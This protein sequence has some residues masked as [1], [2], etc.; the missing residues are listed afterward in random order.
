MG[1]TSARK[2]GRTEWQANREIKLWR[3]R[4]ERALQMHYS[5]GPLI[6]LL[7]PESTPLH[8]SAK[9]HQPL[10]KQNQPRLS[11]WQVRHQ[12]HNMHWRIPCPCFTLFHCGMRSMFGD[13]NVSHFKSQAGSSSS[14]KKANSSNK[15]RDWLQVASYQAVRIALRLFFLGKFREGSVS[16]DYLPGFGQVAL[17][18]ITPSKFLIPQF[19]ANVHLSSL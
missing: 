7:L 16:R 1:S 17:L 10:I 6:N 12:L 11:V 2:S 9:T 3:E 18:K 4:I 15:S 19:T 14:M 5:S 8:F 13:Q